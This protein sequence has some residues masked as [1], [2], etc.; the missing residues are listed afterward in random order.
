MQ[1]IRL[2]NFLFE[3]L[4]GYVVPKIAIRKAVQYSCKEISGHGGYVFVAEENEAAL[5][6]AVINKTGMGGYVTENFL[7]F[8]AV[9]Q[10]H[11]NQ[12][13]GTKLLKYAQQ[14]CQGGM[15]LH[16]K[17]NDKAMSFFRSLGFEEK[18]IEMRY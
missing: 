8:I 4:D 15:A 14:Y 2:T 7:V 18:F 17:P 16:C 1:S 10:D 13:I 12:G 5:G 9:H 11:R 6:V 3:H